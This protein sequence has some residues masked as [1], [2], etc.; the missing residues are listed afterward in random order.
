MCCAALAFC[1]GNTGCNGLCIIP[2]GYTA[3]ISACALPRRP[4]MSRTRA[5]AGLTCRVWHAASSKHVQRVRQWSS[6]RMGTA[7]PPTKGA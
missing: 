1:H 7:Q 5:I 6:S 3:Y 4:V 2:A